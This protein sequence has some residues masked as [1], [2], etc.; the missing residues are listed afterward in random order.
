MDD[1]K[2]RGEKLGEFEIL[3]PE[4]II[5]GNSHHKAISENLPFTSGHA[6][7]IH[8][9]ESS[10]HSER[11]QVFRNSLYTYNHEHQPLKR[12]IQRW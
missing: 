9:I 12:Q 8:G 5:A 11:P 10:L 6:P 7:S 3:F 1:R 4:L 2:T